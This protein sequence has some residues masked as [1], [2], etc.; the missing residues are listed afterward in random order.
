MH[1]PLQIRPTVGQRPLYRTSLVLFIFLISDSGDD[2]LIAIFSVPLSV[3]ERKTVRYGDT[4]P[5]EISYINYTHTTYTGGG[6]HA[7]CRRYIC[8]YVYC[9]HSV[10]N[11]YSV[12]GICIMRGHLNWT[13]LSTKKTRHISTCKKSHVCVSHPRLFP[14]TLTHPSVYR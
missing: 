3:D 2:W 5:F 4:H 6:T 14:P 7:R 11:V 1:W 12:W 13:P 8:T 10:H 9:V